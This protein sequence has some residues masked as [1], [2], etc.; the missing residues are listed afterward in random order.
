MHHLLGMPRVTDELI[1]DKA[2]WTRWVEELQ[3]RLNTDTGV[4]D[5]FQIVP[6][7]PA[8]DANGDEVSG[9]LSVEHW[10]HGIATSKQI[11]A[12]FFHSSRLS[13]DCRDG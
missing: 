3:N 12:D 2:K 11:P 7:E 6:L 10:T 4:S 8:E 13:E 9:G 1:V 5:R